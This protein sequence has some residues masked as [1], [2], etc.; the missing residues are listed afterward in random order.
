MHG[1]GGGAYSRI[2]VGIKQG[3]WNHWYHDIWNVAKN[4]AV[5]SIKYLF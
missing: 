2:T 1:R 3:G 5:N 4:I